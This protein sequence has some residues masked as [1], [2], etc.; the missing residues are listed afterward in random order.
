[1]AQ[2]V[3][4]DGTRTVCVLTKLDLMDAGTHARAILDNELIPLTHGYAAVVNRGQRDVD[5]GVPIAQALV[6]EEAFFK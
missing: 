6:K 4:S 5:A 2:R 1:M 3:D